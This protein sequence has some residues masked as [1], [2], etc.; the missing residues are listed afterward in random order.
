MNPE[1]DYKIIWQK[2]QDELIDNENL[3]IEDDTNEESEDEF[4]EPN[5]ENLF[6]KKQSILITPMGILPYNEAMACNKIFNL[7]VG[8]TNFTINKYI[9]EILEQCDGVEA[10]D[11]F[12]RYRFRIAIGNAFSDSTVMRNINNKIYDYLH[13]TN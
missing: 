2:W 11:V 8:H 6:A 5:T 3:D 7:W 4:T 9:A 1:F 13:D 12:T 10:L